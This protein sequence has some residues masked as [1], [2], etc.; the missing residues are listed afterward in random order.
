MSEI[1]VVVPVYKAELYLRRCV[2]SI[3]NQTFS[4]FDLILIDDGSPDQCPL[5]CDQYAQADPRVHVIHQKNNGPSAAR[6]QGID[7]AFSQSSSKYL[8]FADSD[9]YLHPQFLEHLYHSVE[10]HLA[11]IG[12]CRH[13]Y[14]AAGQKLGNVGLFDSYSAEEIGAEDLMVKESSGFNYIWGKLYS[15]ECFKN[16]RFPAEI[17]FGEDNLIIFKTMFECRKIVFVENPLY[18]YFYTPTGITKSPWTPKSLDVF[19]G[20]RAQMEYYAQHGY[21]KAYKKETELYIQ[22]YAHQI[23]RICEDQERISGNK[24][25]LR[26]LRKEMRVVLRECDG[27]KATD[28]FFWYEAL[29]PGR[30]KIRNAAGRIKRM[31]KRKRARETVS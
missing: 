15:K 1:T 26:K 22:Q 7:W 28:S 8:A 29:Y 18:Y 17:S 14:V 21:Q 19:Q 24:A 3:L 20:I 23:H 11:D 16:L 4:D 10:S 13:Q 30:A 25:Y 5:I 12:M 6:N 2:D 31:I 27:Y 9:D